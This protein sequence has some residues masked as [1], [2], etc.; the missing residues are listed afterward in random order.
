M[1]R[2]VLVLAW[3]FRGGACG[4][5]LWMLWRRGVMDLFE[6]EKGNST[7]AEWIGRLSG[8]D[9]LGERGGIRACCEG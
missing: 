1:V 2:W 4:L 9:A 8:S 5:R 3:G 6:M 7:G